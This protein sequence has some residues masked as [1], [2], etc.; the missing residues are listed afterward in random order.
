MPTTLGSVLFKKIYYPDRD[1]VRRRQ[2]EKS[3]ALLF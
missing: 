1:G 3:L 2:V